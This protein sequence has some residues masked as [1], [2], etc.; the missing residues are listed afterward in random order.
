MIRLVLV[1]TDRWRDNWPDDTGLCRAI[2]IRGILPHCVVP[3][4]HTQAGRTNRHSH[5]FA[6]AVLDLG[7]PVD[8]L[9]QR[10]V[11]HVN[12]TAVPVWLIVGE[13]EVIARHLYSHRD[14]VM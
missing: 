14:V 9:V 1:A 4:A 12:R 5:T 8:C 10:D 6:I 7:T 3:E 11:D 13:I 2:R